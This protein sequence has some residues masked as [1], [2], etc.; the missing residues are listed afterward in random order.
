MIPDRKAHPRSGHVLVA[1]I[2]SMAIWVVIV[3]WTLPYLRRISGGLEPFDLRPFGYDLAEAR[4]LLFALSP[5]GR[6]YYL[7]IQLSLDN[8]FP[9]TYAFS[10]VLLLLWLT[11]PGRLGGRVIPPKWRAALLVLPIA[12]AT[13]DYIENNA[14]AAM[15]VA[16]PEVD[17]ETVAWASFWTQAKSVGALLTDAIAV[18]MLVTVFNR[19]WQRRQHT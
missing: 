14:I 15:L 19:W 11:I 2:I 9:F 18:I 16:G 10:R 13:C 3:F 5:I 4:K 7:N 8:A 1:M 17:A 6:D 12:T